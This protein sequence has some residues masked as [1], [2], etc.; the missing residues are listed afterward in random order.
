MNK[1]YKQPN[2]YLLFLLALFFIALILSGIHPVSFYAWLGQVAAG[3][4]LVV[5]LIVTYPKFQFS[6]F[7]YT[8]VFFHLLLLLYGA[9]YTYAE[10]PFFNQLRDQFNWERNYFDRVGHFAQG[11][12]PAFLFKE[13]Y[14]K[15]G[16]V[17]KGKVLTAIVILSC[18]GFSAGY[19]LSEF[20]VIKILRLPAES[21]MGMQGDFF[22]SHWDMLW[23][24]IGALVSVF[25]F[26]GYHDRQFINVK[27]GKDDKK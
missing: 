26:D 5:V 22:D 14:L 10:N 12:V 4:I 27:I 21:V 15:G 2:K 24:L 1:K 25:V 3:T 9:H 7:A 19:E 20:A 17:K 6:N 18:L 11:F 13:F 23:A 16:Y 8:L